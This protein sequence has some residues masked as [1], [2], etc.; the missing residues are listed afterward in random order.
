[1]L[2]RYA[3]LDWINAHSAKVIH[4]SDVSAGDWFFEPVMEATMGHDFT[5]DKDGKAE[6]WTDLNGKSFI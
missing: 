4:F 5:R 2:N 3:D 1:M 6:H